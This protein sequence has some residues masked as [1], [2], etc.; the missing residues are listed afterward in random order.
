[1]TLDPNNDVYQGDLSILNIRKHAWEKA[2]DRSAGYRIASYISLAVGLIVMVFVSIKFPSGSTIVS[3]LPLHFTIWGTALVAYLL[4]R[5]GK[6]L[7]Q[8][9]FVGFHSA[10]FEVSDDTI[11]YVYQKGM[12]LYTYYIKDS[13]I[14]KIYRDEESGVLLIKGK[15]IINERRRKGETETPTDEFYALVPFD[16]YDLDD[17]L[18]PYRKYVVKADGQL[19]EKYIREHSA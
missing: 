1:M 11:Y 9:P 3:R 12:A 19:R 16:K 15:A 6:K 5:Q 2:D 7:S 14:K 13:N 18:A 10:R 8:K 17:L 4:M